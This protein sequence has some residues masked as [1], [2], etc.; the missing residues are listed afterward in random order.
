[1]CMCGDYCCPSCGPAQGNWKCELCGE[2]AS[3]GCEH[4]DEET[5]YYKPEFAAKIERSEAFGNYDNGHM[6]D[7]RF[8]TCED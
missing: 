6:N 2:W 4:I 1:M 5:G 7:V 3:E 8:G